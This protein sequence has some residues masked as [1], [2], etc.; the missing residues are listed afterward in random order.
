MITLKKLHYSLLVIILPALITGFVSSTTEKR[1]SWSQYEGELVI[2]G[3]KEE[4]TVF[5]DERG[6]PHIYAGNE[7]DL[8]MVV[9]YISAR[10]RLWQMDLIRRSS[11]GRLSEIFGRSF[12]EADKLMRCLKISEKSEE[13]LKIQPPEI[14]ECLQAYADGVNAFIRRCHKD[15]PQE[16]RILTYSPEEWT[17]RDITNIVG[18]MG[19]NLT[20]RNLTSELFYHEVV[21]KL[22]IEK[23]VQLIPDW[24][25]ETDI[26]YPDFRLDDDL[27]SEARSLISSFDRV[28]RFGIHSFSGSNNW[29]VSGSRTE[30]GKP[31]LSNDMHLSLGLPGVWIQMHQVVKGRLDVTGVVIPGEPFVIAGHNERIAWGLTS[32]MVDDV[33][34][35]AEKINPENQNQYYFNGEWTGMTVRKEVITI[36][37]RKND[38][39]EIRSTHRGPVIPGTA[40]V[41]NSSLS[42]RW[43]GFDP[44]NEIRTAYLLNRAENWEDFRE[45]ISTFR[46]ISQ[47]FAYADVDGNIGL[48]TGGGIPVRKGNGALIRNGETDEFD[49]KGYVPFEQLPSS[50]NPP[51]GYVSSANNKTVTDD[52]PYYVSSEFVM[53]YRIKRIREMIEGKDMLCQED[54]RRMVNDQHSVFASLL[55][56]HIL[57]LSERADDLNRTE[58]DAL[59][60][61]SGWDYNMNKDLVAPAIFEHF[62]KSYKKNLLADEL[63]ELYDRLYYMTGEYY[64]YKLLVNGPDEWVD[65]INTPEKETPDDIIMQSFK[66]SIAELAQNYGKHIDRWKWGKIHELTFTH[67][68]GTVKILDFLFKLNSRRFGVG[69]SDH[70]VSPYFSFESEFKV[71]NGA[72][73]RHVLNTADWDES[74]SVIPCGISGVPGSEF[75][76]SQAEAYIE[77]KF[78]KDLFSENAVRSSAKYTLRLI[79]EK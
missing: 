39:V 3:L 32:L 6:M 15:L 79:P 27:I 26:I 59:E 69:G 50:F 61:L 72:S 47:N 29:A 10:E 65:N 28:G 1:R 42:M 45:A 73:V 23:A 51:E 12:V 4:V 25:V 22:G 5:T 35:F 17:L 74:E 55:V 56:P 77:G 30:T 71:G 60:I 70:T 49:W 13:I 53:P 20:S 33:D 38:T 7:H 31:L 11:T 64:L 41:N 19:W 54:F 40:N 75:Y 18:Y 9:G 66:E 67:P 43:S 78:Y 2:P 24:N 37:G 76:L 52:Y 48:N 8:Y 44:S 14:M 16:F 46:T 21:K 57:K 68:L 34:L 58:R 63:G 36:R 62:R